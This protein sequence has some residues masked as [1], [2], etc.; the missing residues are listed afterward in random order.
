M[1][2]PRRHIRFWLPL[3]LSLLSIVLGLGLSVLPLT[4]GQAQDDDEPEPTPVPPPMIALN[5][6]TIQRATVFV[7]QTYQTQDQTIISCVGSGTLVASDGLILTNAHIAQPS[8]ICR[9]DRI[10]I[11]I[12]VHLD[13]PPVPS[14]VA[15]VVNANQGLD[16][17]TLR[18]TNYLDGRAVEANSLILPFVELGDSS[19]TQLDDTI[20]IVGY[21][22]FGK[23]AQV[24]DVANS[25]VTSVR[26]TISGFT[27]EAQAGDRAWIRTTA[28][29]PGVMSGGGAYDRSGRLIGIPTIAP[30]RLSGVVEDCRV[31][32]DTTGDGRAD[33]NDGCVP[34][35]GFITALRPSRLARGLVRAATLGISEGESSSFAAPITSTTQTEE[36]AL[37]RMFF[38]TSVSSN[39]VPASVVGSV[40]GGTSSLYLFFDYD[41][42]RD[43]LIYELKVTVDDI[44][45]RVHSL[46]PGTWSGGERGTWY[47]GSATSDET[48]WQPGL[49]VFR[50]F[51]EGREADNKSILIGSRGSSEPPPTFSSILFA[52]LDEGTGTLMSTGYVLP[53]GT[54]VHAE[55]SYLNMRP[56]LNW[57]QVWYKDGGALEPRITEAW[58]EE[59]GSSG[60]HIIN[61]QAVGAQFDA[62][63]YRLELYIE[64]SL[65]ATADFVVAGGAVM[66]GTEIFTG[67]RFSTEQAGGVPVEETV[68]AEFPPAIEQLYVF[69]DWR[70]IAPG[71]LW[72]RRWLVDNEVLFQVTEPWR[73]PPDGQNLFFSL[74]SLGTLPDGTYAFEIQI[75]NVTQEVERV[76]VG[77]GQLPVEVFESAEGAQMSG[78][79]TDAETG[80]GIPGA[81]FIVLEPEFSIED[82]LWESRQIRSLSTADENGRFQVPILLRRGTED[83]P[84]LYSIM[85]MADGYLP[86]SADGILVDNTTESP[87]EI[88]VELTPN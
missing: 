13:E 38:A 39:G 85:V 22:D 27:A 58:P 63:Y 67:F 26:G 48:T 70:L 4:S 5:Q 23:E 78:T 20:T 76:R 54:F 14:Y 42:M 36:P 46:P 44:P 47:I 31:I 87:V 68:R 43:G 40:P 19:A 52:T 30:A 62:G 72:T 75:A 77:L 59:R 6:E 79:I 60:T 83:E 82:F 61:A 12:T 81:M 49:Y 33:R 32:Q 65:S 34:I 29:I 41:N 73:A 11:A 74:D 66:L 35:G 21:P 15:E 56:G 88:N 17:A 28:E 84:L 57:T 3:T 80:A 50:I 69:F 9:S 18:I 45:D 1:N 55:F 25:P 53:E 51:I 64:G 7:M 2:T 37:S 8:D 24:L 86:V 71:T 16:L 10:V